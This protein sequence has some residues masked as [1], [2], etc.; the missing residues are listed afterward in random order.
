[1]NY[2]KYNVAIYLVL[3]YLNQQAIHVRM[4]MAVYSHAC[5]HAYYVPVATW[6]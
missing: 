2:I 4:L 3:T 1:M 5:M 6:L